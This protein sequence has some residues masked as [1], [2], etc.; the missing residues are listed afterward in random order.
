MG[1]SNSNPY[2][3]LVAHA[4]LLAFPTVIAHQTNTNF[5]QSAIKNIPAFRPKFIAIHIKVLGLKHHFHKH[6]TIIIFPIEKG[7]LTL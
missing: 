7:V 5:D 1:G 3:S 6:F 2:E 4:S